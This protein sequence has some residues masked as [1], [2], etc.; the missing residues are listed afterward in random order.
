MVIKAKKVKE[1]TKKQMAEKILQCSSLMGV[2]E[3]MFYNK[4]NRQDKG[5][6][7][8]WYHTVTNACSEE[9][10]KRYADRAIKDILQGGKI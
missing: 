7:R 2:S 5:T 10:K 8:F 9:A 3:T 6:I 4:V 1:Q